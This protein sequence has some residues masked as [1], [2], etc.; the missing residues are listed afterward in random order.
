MSGLAQFNMW[1]LLLLGT[2]SEVTRA[3][4]ANA[5]VMRGN[6]RRDGKATLSGLLGCSVTV[7]VWVPPAEGVFTLS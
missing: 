5:K 2:S 1:M 6:V 4:V 7:C 3:Q